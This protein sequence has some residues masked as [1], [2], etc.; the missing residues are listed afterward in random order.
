[1]DTTL[2]IHKKIAASQA[3]SGLSANNVTLLGASKSQS[4]EAILDFID[5]GVADFGENRVQE[6]VEKWLPIKAVHPHVRLHLIGPLQT[7]KVKEALSLFDVIQTLDRPK[8]AEAIAKQIGEGWRVEGE[9]ISAATRHPP[10]TTRHYFIQVNT[11]AEPQ[12]AGIAPNETKDFI[13]YCREL[14]LNVVGLMCV[15]PADLQPA[16]H[17]ALLRKLALE[18]DLSGLSMGMSDDYETAI[19]MGSSCVRLGRVLFGARDN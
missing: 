15:P 6:A 12:K 4:A 18:N 1:M 10:L 5:Q 2:S 16:P 11:G 19:R 9:V 17:F 14:K 8:L 3:L 13:A 7:N